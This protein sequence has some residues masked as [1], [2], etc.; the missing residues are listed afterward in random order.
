VS[1]HTDRP[2][3][4]LARRS[5]GWIVATATGEVEGDAVVLALPAPA[6]ARLVQPHDSDAAGLLSTIAYASVTTVT[7]RVPLDRLTRPL[8]GTGFLVPRHSP[9]G[10]GQDPWSVTACT[11]LCR[12][13]PHLATQGEV[14][15]RVSLGRYG[16][17]RPSSWTDAEVVARAWHELGRLAGVTGDPVEGRVVRWPQALPQYRVHHLLRTGGIESALARL[18]GIAGAGAALRGVGIPACIASGRAAARAIS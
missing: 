11:Y 6:A 15:L 13:W 7:L 16:D 8:D 5:G 4:S 3:T 1:I 10:R 9:V 17:D 14:L 12:K 2:A 18:G